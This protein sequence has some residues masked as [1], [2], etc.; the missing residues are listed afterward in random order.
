MCVTADHVSEEC[1]LSQWICPS[2]QHK[3]VH[4]A[5]C[6][7]LSLLWA[8]LV[9]PLSRTSLESTGLEHRARSVAFAHAPI[10][11]ERE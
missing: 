9:M 4:R 2:T 3:L 8:H 1:I 10:G 5:A 11:R 7:S 6:S